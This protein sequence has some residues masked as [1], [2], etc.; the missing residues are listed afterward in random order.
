MATQTRV[1]TSDVSSS[2]TWNHATN[3]Y[4][5]VDEGVDANDGDTT[6]LTQTV[7]G[8]GT[9]YLGFSAFTIPAGSTITQLQYR[10][11]F[12]ILSDLD[13]SKTATQRI[14]VGGT[15]Y[16]G[17]VHTLT[18]TWTTYTSTWATNP[19]TS[20]AWTVDDINGSG[21]NPL[22]NFGFALNGTSDL[23]SETARELIVTYTP[24]PNA[25]ISATDSATADTAF[26]QMHANVYASL[27]TTEYP[28]EDTAALNTYINRSLQLATT[29]LANDYINTTNARKFIGWGTYLGS[30][31]T[32]TQ[33]SE[34]PF[35]G[36]S[37]T[38]VQI[39][40]GTSTTKYYRTAVAP[41]GSGVK[42][43]MGMWVKNIG[44][45][46][47]IIHSN[48]STIGTV[49][50][51]SGWQYVFGIF[52]GNGVSAFQTVFK[53]ALAAHD[54]D[55]YA[56][57]PT[58]SLV[59]D[60]ADTSALTLQHLAEAYISA[61]EAAV[62]DTSNLQLHAN[63]Y[64]YLFANEVGADVSNINMTVL[65]QAHI[66]AVEAG[67]DVVAAY[68]YARIK[69]GTSKKFNRGWQYHDHNYNPSEF[70]LYT[71]TRPE[72]AEQRHTQDAPE[73]VV[74]SEDTTHTPTYVKD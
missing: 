30:V 67:D 2:G 48:L 10:S 8:S 42:Y 28:G 3:K 72:S 9:I 14:T 52:T 11:V 51:G 20:A 73:T 71:K 17:T 60:V 39:T 74:T 16:N 23:F 36:S 46:D 55:V 45:Q 29:E 43:R 53:T 5:Y 21:A 64:L 31:A 57:W 61:V 7:G 24:P 34:D 37:G 33:S 32:L 58:G 1:P 70:G 25:Y 22:Q 65:L 40:G 56:W 26:L 27:V 35:S 66:A 38:R 68:L 54:I 44:T 12:K 18:T 13:P 4:T 6:T 50:P 19:K 47:V 15:G 49:T 62:E 59:S 41:S 63:D 69:Y